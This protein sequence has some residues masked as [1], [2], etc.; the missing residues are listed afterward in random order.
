MSVKHDIYEEARLKI[1]QKLSISERRP[2][3]EGDLSESQVEQIN[4]HAN[5]YGHTSK[6]VIDA[7]I[8]NEVAFRFIL[9]RNPS[10][11]GYWETALVDYLNSLSV[12]Q[13]AIQLPKS[14]ANRLYIVKGAL[15]SQKPD[16]LHVKS[17]DIQV[18]FQNGATAYIIH[19]YT[20]E[21]GGAQDNQW[22][23]ANAALEQIH[24][25]SPNQVRL[26]LIAV[27]D[28]AYYVQPRRNGSVLTRLEETRQSHPDAIVC[29]YQQFSE[30]TRGIWEK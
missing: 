23:E 29:T 8:S 2:T 11:M 12:V 27:L 19:K 30:A 13:K 20:A 18:N 10:R 9:G 24:S 1:L 6:E 16:A 17:L 28:G 21:A 15:V 22:R 3:W 25:E 14:G 4:A 7:V 5:R 26:N